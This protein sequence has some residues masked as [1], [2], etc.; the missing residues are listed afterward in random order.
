MNSDE[1]A[2]EPE[3]KGPGWVVKFF[4]PLSSFLRRS[5]ILTG[6]TLVSAVLVV[7]IPQWFLLKNGRTDP[8]WA[9][10]SVAAGIVI[11]VAVVLDRIADAYEKRIAAGTL[12]GSEES[13]ENTVTDLNTFISEALEVTFLEGNARMKHIKALRRIL[14]LCAAKC[15]GPGSRA[16]YYTLR[17]LPDKT[18]ILGAPQHHC[19]YGRYDK[20][21]RP[22]I[23]T[24]D[25]DHSVWQIMDGPDQEPR[26]HS[27][28]EEIYGLDW[29]RKKYKTFISVPVKAGEVQFG[30]L[31]VN[32]ARVGAIGGPQQA[33]IL[34][35]ARIFALVLSNARGPRLMNSRQGTYEMSD[36]DDTVTDKTKGE[37]N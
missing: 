6:L 9:P 7:G 25:T 33:T 1:M 3:K 5:F 31:S 29:T 37:S 34:A 28:G 17:V 11:A 35:M 12:T 2:P 19:E 13:A 30:F 10:L 27:E 15:V 4:G 8:A 22:F 32:N 26:V 21:S 36:G 16:T 24:E 18:R 23:E 14:V 20:P